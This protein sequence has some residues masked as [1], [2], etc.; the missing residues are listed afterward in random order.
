[1]DIVY[2]FVD[3][4]DTFW[5]KEY[6]KYLYDIKGLC[7]DSATKN[8]F[9]SQLN[10]LY[11][12]IK[13]ISK[14]IKS[15]LIKSVYVVVSGTSQLINNKLDELIE[16]TNNKLII[17][18]HKMIIPSSFLPTFNSLCI[19][20]YLHKIPGLTESFIYFNDDIIVNNLDKFINHVTDSME[21]DKSVI[22][23]SDEKIDE[24]LNSSHEWGSYQ[25]T[26]NS[27]LGLIKQFYNK[28]IYKLE[29]A[30]Y[31]LNKTLM[32]ELYNKY[33]IYCNETSESKFRRQTDICL[34]AFMYQYYAISLDK[35]III[36]DEFISSYIDVNKCSDKMDE[37][38]VFLSIQDDYN[39]N[40][41]EYQ[42]TKEIFKKFL[43]KLT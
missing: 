35:A 19:E 22:Y 14:L 21:Q 15:D 12:S 16:L 34:T 37:K 33:Q 24:Y 10:E 4:D 13:S 9:N 32:N 27:S 42:K 39:G 41:G 5:F 8:R 20:L 1:M 29:H 30:P 6:E 31:F 23:L 17:I 18:P 40:D 43:D 11:Y 25:H 36:R 2:T 26:L 3:G 7:C 38:Y 28:T